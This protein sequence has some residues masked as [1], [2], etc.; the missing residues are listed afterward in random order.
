MGDA[1]ERYPF[2][3]DE[4]IAA[5]RRIREE[6]SAEPAEMPVMPVAVRMN[7]VVND[8]PFGDGRLAAHVDTSGDGLEIELGHV[9]RPDLTVTLAYD[10]ARALL[11]DGDAAAAMNAFLGGRI[12]VDGDI[13][14][15]L[16]LQSSGGAAAGGPSAALL[17]R[18][19]QDITA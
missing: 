7:M 9:E 5:A 19:L 13:T 1:A 12:R 8:V 14:K 17:A 4:W 15:L 6:H 3:S 11:V 18:R 2:L 10:T 16:A